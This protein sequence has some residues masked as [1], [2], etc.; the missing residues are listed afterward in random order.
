MKQKLQDTTLNRFENEE[1]C[2]V[3]NG[4]TD[5]AGMVRIFLFEIDLKITIDADL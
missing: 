1:L 4:T 3:L 2:W 5:L